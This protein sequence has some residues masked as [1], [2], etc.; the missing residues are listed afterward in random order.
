MANPSE[1]D[2]Q[3][4]RKPSTGGLVSMAIFRPAEAPLTV[5]SA[6]HAVFW[7]SQTPADISLFRS[8]SQR[9]F[10]APVVSGA[11]AGTPAAGA[12][13]AITAGEPATGFAVLAL[14]R[15]CAAFRCLRSTGSV[16]VA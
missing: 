4:H 15:A 12:G 16:S 1:E 3:A 10:W 6:C 11:G 14:F 13:T 9:A 7:P 8:E 2:R 5:A